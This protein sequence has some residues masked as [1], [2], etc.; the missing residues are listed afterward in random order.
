V[1][2]VADCR[3]ALAKLL[4][5]AINDGK[6]MKDGRQV[7]PRTG[8]LYEMTSFDDVLKAYQEQFS[9]WTD[10]L[11]SSVE[12][13]D[14]CQQTY[15]PLPLLSCFMHDCTERG[16]DVACGGTTYNYTGA[17]ACGLGTLTDGLAT[18]KQLVFEEH[19]VSSQELYDAVKANWEG[20]QPLLQLVNS[21]KVH[22]YGNDDD[23]ADEIA[24]WIFNLYCDTVKGHPNARGGIFSPGVFSVAANVG[25]GVNQWASVE[26]RVAGEP[27][28]DGIGPVHTHVASHDIRGPMAMLRS[29][30]KL[31][32]SK[33]T[34]GTLLNWMFDP[35][36]V[37]GETGGENFVALLR[38]IV[39]S[40]TM[41]SQ[42]NVIARE[43]L[44]DAKAHP[45]NYRSLLVRVA[46]YSALFVTLGSALQQ[47]IIE[48]TVY[49][50]D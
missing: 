11:F 49:S 16:R 45:E 18:L 38:Q 21:D 43:T 17:E 7:G 36:A 46:G 42:F 26:G 33:A 32:H 28:S 13:A 31:D 29:V 37:S 23:Y 9:Y 20:Y 1:P 5:L 50:F 22:H 48:R 30:S 44:E 15:K 34:N 24:Q 4:E 35:G 2:I 39:S 14:L 41:H 3:L 40:K 27:I 10:T 47:D 6:W 8:Y 25:H 19:K 12:T